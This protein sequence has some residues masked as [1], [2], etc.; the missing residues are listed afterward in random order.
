MRGIGHELLRHATADHAGAADAVMLGDRDPG[1]EA[2][3]DAA[4][5]NAPGAGT[6]DEQVVVS[7]HESPPKQNAP[8][9]GVLSSR[10]Y[11]LRIV[12]EAL[13]PLGARRMAE[14]AQRLR[15]DLA[16]ALARHIEL[17]AD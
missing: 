13:Q 1:A 12:E 15:L 2:R 8:V 10:S 6:D 7:H 9:R 17:L 5:A 11:G 4:G 3:G 16:D 14:L